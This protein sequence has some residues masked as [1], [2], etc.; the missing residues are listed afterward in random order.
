MNN[1]FD[2]AHFIVKL[3][4]I[5]LLSSTMDQFHVGLTGQTD[6]TPLGA[7]GHNADRGYQV[8][9]ESICGFNALCRRANASIMASCI[10]GHLSSPLLRPPIEIS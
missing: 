9:R 1:F 2:A 8:S 6:G 3:C 7:T 10:A 5:S 4:E